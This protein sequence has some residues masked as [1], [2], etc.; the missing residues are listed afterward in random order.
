MEKH[1]EGPWI[2]N[3]PWHIQAPTRIAGYRDNGEAIPELPRIL[4][5]IVQGHSV[6]SEERLANAEL[7]AAAPAMYKTLQGLVE[8]IKDIASDSEGRYPHPN[9]G[10]IECTVGT[11]PDKYNTGLCALHMAKSL[12]SKGVE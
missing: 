4:A 1:T 5:Q 11:V 10:C 12:L 6:D 8:L 2:L 7:I 9:T 3:G